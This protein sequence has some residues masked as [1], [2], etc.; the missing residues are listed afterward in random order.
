MTEAQTAHAADL[1]AKAIHA[2]RST[3][4]GYAET[5]NATRAARFSIEV[6]RIP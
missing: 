2:A 4:Y 6:K 3:G 1:A 5:S